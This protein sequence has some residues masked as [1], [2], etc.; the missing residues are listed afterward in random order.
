MTTTEL[1]KALREALPE[2]VDYAE[3]VGA[4]EWAYGCEYVYEDPECYLI[5]EAAD[6]LEQ[7]QQLVD[8]MTNDHYV[9]YLEFYENRCRE[10]EEKM[11][12]ILHIISDEN[13]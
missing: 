9:D 12:E 7:L 4:P 11:S 10:L 1:I 5:E 13:T 6:K 8:D 2:P 3:L